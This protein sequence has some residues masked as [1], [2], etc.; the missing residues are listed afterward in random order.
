MG[1][2]C[3]A[4]SS[5][6]VLSLIGPN[7]LLLAQEPTLLR[8]YS[9]NG[10]K[11]VLEDLHLDIE[12]TIEA[13]L[14]FEFS[15]SRTLA[16][17]VLSGESFDVV[18]L[19]PALIDELIA[20]KKVDSNSRSKFSQVGVGVGSR[21]GGLVKSVSTLDDLREVLLG[22]E[23][24]AYGENGQSRRTNEASFATLGITE[25]VH[26]KRRLTGPG[27]GPQLV[28]EGEVE[29]VL[30]LVSELIREPGVQFLGVLPPEVQRYI[31]FEAA[32]GIAVKDS[33]NGREFIRFLSSPEFSSALN[34]HGLEFISQ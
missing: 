2:V 9:S 34:K 21:Q 18:I 7:S 25:E 22:A 13:T 12:R 8:V 17:K 1:L 26:K 23:S 11:A 4:L 30:T 14:S 3:K 6:L 5:F 32:M 33:V 19:T 29:L 31:Q 28:A 27:K 24:I 20:S 16:D 10:V 15:T